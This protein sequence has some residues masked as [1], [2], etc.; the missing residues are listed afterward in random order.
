M[1]INLNIEASNYL[2]II[3]GEWRRLHRIAL[4]TYYSLVFTD[5][6]RRVLPLDAEVLEEGEIRD[7]DS[8]VG[9]ELSSEQMVVQGSVFC[10]ELPG[11][12]ESE[13]MIGSERMYDMLCDFTGC[14]RIVMR[15]RFPQ[16][17][18]NNR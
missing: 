18:R 4:N 14:H 7:E 6:A 5:Q 1:L 10:I 15:R 11:R 3:K 2:S 16:R 12:D 9:L 13:Y 8:V 17:P